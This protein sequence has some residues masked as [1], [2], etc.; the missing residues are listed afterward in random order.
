MVVMLTDAQLATL[1][2]AL[3]YLL[4]ESHAAVEPGWLEDHAGV[5]DAALADAV[6][7]LQPEPATTLGC[8]AIDERRE[9]TRRIQHACAPQPGAFDPMPDDGSE[10]SL[11]TSF[12][13]LH[14]IV[15]EYLDG[16]DQI[17]EGCDCGRHA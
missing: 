17:V 12:A 1:H 14:G 3:G 7:A 10:R 16:G 11:A 5:S 9:L 13:V 4:D 15:A 6:K 8:R 2:A